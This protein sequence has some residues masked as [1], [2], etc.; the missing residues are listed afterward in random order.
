LFAATFSHDA[1]LVL[2]VSGDKTARIWNRESG[3]TVELKGHQWAVLSGQFSPD[4]ARV[5]TGSQDKTAKI[6]DAETG[7]ELMTL[8]GHTAP[9]TSVAFSPDDTRALT[10]SQDY[11]AKLWDVS[12]QQSAGGK[13]AGK[14]ILSLAG[15]AQE[16]T[17]VSFSPDGRNVLTSSRDGK[18][19]VWLADDWR[20][21][22]VSL[23][24][25]R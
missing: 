8:E 1:K 2:T 6:W 5:I 21:D 18:A 24:L 23:T 16:V 17:S 7:N 4:G 14:E 13:I 3:K 22:A 11:T 15:H 25:G 12:Q 19:I 9:V 20:N 10:G